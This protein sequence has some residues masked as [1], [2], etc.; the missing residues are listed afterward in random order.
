MLEKIRLALRFNTKALDAEIND[1]IDAALLDLC[2]VGVDADA[3]DPKKLADSLICKACELYCKWQF[4][5]R[6][7]GEQFRQNYESL[8]DAMSLC[9][10]YRSGQDE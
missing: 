10:K 3:E 8:R 2:R 7:K 5:F 1:N 4:D 6:G 9:S